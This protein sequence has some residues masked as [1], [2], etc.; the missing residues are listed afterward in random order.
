METKLTWIVEDPVLHVQIHKDV[1]FQMIVKVRTASI[2]IVY[3]L[4]APMEFK[5]VK[6]SMWIVVVDVSDVTFIKVV[7]SIKIV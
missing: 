1:N 4:P 3:P 7:K 2:Y 6:K 5:M